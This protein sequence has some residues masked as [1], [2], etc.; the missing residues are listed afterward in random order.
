MKIKENLKKI[1]DLAVERKAS[2]IHLTAN[3]QPTLRIDG[4]L[5]PLNDFPINTK[6]VLEDFV[7]QLLTEDKMEKLKQEKELDT[8]ISYETASSE[9]GSVR[10]RVHIFQQSG[11]FAIV[12][13]LIPTKI[14]R[15]KDLGIPPVVKKFATLPNGLVLITGVTGSGK[16]TTLASLIDEINRNFSK[17]IVTV[18]DPIEFIHKHNK[19]IVNQREIGSD[20]KDFPRAVRAAMRED[21][22]ILLVGEMRDLETIQNAITMAET[23]HLV[24][25]TLHTK[26]AAETISRIIDI[27][28]PEQQSQIRTQLASSIKGI[29]SQHLIPK[30]DGGRIPS[31][32]VLV[33]TP[34]IQSMIREN[35]NT[36]SILDQIEMKSKDLGSQ[37]HLQSVAKLLVAKKI[38]LEVAKTGLSAEDVQRLNG[39]IVAESKKE[40]NY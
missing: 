11:F 21:P 6:E 2:D 12:L 25:G 22:D 4:V 8:S 36:S 32:E 33:T 40:S 24:F 7:E 34:A 37:T 15:F 13:R 19:S 5:T 31:C 28:P 16:S 35:K 23:G 38:T 29:L 20:V 27:F 9:D 14:P 10:F 1:F 18:E 39:L 17:H 30:I 3:L 26:S